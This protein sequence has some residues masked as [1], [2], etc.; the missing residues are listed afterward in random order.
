M[1]A[2]HPD[3]LAAPI[4]PIRH[5]RRHAFHATDKAGQIFCLPKL[6]Q[7]MHMVWHQNP[8]VNG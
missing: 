8:T 2:S 7:Q 3:S 4:D 5:V 6:N 1:E